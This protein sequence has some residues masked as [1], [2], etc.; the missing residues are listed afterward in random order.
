[1]IERENLKEVISKEELRSRIAEIG[2]EISNT[3]N[4]ESVVFVVVLNGGF[5]FAS[6]LIRAV[7]IECEVDF[8]KVA[9]YSGMKSEGKINFEKD[10]STEKAPNQVTNQAVF[11]GSTAELQKLLKAKRG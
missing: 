4:L 10:L 5:I 2:A 7:D 6:D 11:V 8:I 1:M 9:S 3:Y